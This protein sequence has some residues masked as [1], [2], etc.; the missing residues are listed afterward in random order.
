MTRLRADFWVSA[1]LLQ[2]QTMGLFAFIVHKGDAERGGIIIK[3]A[4]LNGSAK[5]YERSIDFDNN[6][7][8]RAL[9]P[10]G[11]EEEDKADERLRK[12]LALDPDLWVIEI[13]DPRGDYIFDAPILV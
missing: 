4:P 11:G 13:E 7:I 12:R 10:E 8:W 5:L 6:S 3:H 1:Q 9:G 2:L